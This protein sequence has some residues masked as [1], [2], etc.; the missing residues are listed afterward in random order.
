MDHGSNVA[1]PSHT[2]SI[3]CLK[4]REFFNFKQSEELNQENG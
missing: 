4:H 1:G 2:F 3:L